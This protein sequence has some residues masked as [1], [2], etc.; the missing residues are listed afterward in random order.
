M[1]FKALAKYQDFVLIPAHL[2]VGGR[3]GRSGSWRS[4]ENEAVEGGQLKS[5]RPLWRCPLR[6][7]TQ[8]RRRVAMVVVGPRDSWAAIFLSLS[9]RFYLNGHRSFS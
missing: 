3:K 6:D 2:S 1:V 9:N 5:S 8:R 4:P 7:G